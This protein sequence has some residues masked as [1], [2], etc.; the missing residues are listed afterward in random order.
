[1]P[2]A[3]AV[4]AGLL[5]GIAAPFEARGASFLVIGHARLLLLRHGLLLLLCL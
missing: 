5:D 2:S 4:Q 3:D 1:M